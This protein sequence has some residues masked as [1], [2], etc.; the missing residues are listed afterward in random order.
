MM[1]PRAPPPPQRM[2]PPPPPSTVHHRARLRVP[3]SG[4]RSG[5][6]RPSNPK[7]SMAPGMRPNIP[8]Q[9]RPMRRPAP[10]S[11][12]QQ[13]HQGIVKRKRLDILIPD[14]NDNDDCHVISMQKCNDGLPVIKNVQGA[15]ISD[16]EADPVVH[17][18]DSITLSV[19]NPKEAP[20]VQKKSSDAKSVANILATRGITVTPA[21]KNQKD[22]PEPK[23]S[24]QSSN[25]PPVAINLNNAV[26]IIPTA[27]GGNAQNQA[28]S[29]QPKTPTVDLTD[30]EPVHPPPPPSK[31][32]TTAATI[33]KRA[34]PHQCDLCPA[35]YPTM[36]SL[37]N[38][39][40]SYHK[41]GPQSE[42]GVPVVDLKQPAVLSKLSNLGINNYIP[43]PQLGT[44]GSTFGLPIVSVNAARN[45]NICNISGLG[46]GAVLPLGPLR[47]ISNLSK[48]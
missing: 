13:Q 39:R 36:Q 33:S 47:H 32:T 1:P 4:A 48:Q 22:A 5:P 27:R 3:M 7:N 6:P 2:A 37:I 23:R 45:P 38:H 30:D 8:Q 15:S 28:K 18:T 24:S 21:A 20:V 42:L 17:L 41:T 31:P 35:Q 29:N 46:S 14:T 34:L 11:E 26:S 16:I 44:G 10:S 40:R 25:S 12:Q 43:L 19:R 9:A